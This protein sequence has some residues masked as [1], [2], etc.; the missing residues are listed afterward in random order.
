MTLATKHLAISTWL[1]VFAGFIMMQAEAPLTN[2]LGTAF[3]ILGVTS[4]LLIGISWLS[5]KFRQ[6]LHPIA[7][8]TRRS[9]PDR[10]F[11]ETGR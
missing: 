11:R 2:R 5:A 7:D 1:P 6:R 3:W 10:E 9:D 8:F 4:Q